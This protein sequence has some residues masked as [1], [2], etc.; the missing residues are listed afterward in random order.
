MN[1]LEWQER[2]RNAGYL[3]DEHFSLMIGL[4]VAMQRPLLLEGPA[5]SGKTFLAEALAA[6]TRRQLVRLS[7]YEGIDAAQ[8][9]YDWNYH[10]QLTALARQADVDPFGPGF[11]LERPLMHALTIAHGAVLLIDEVDRADEGFEALLLEFL[12]GYQI[13]VP[14]RD[15][16]RAVVPP[17]TVLTSNRQRSLS[18]ALRRRCLYAYV[19]WPAPARE[20]EIV[21]L[22]VPEMPP[23]LVDALVTGVG[24]LRQFGLL[25][26][27]GL[28]ET[29]DWAR[30]Q[31]VMG[32]PGWQ[33]EWVQATLG[34]VIKDMMDF[35]TVAERL[36][37]L[38]TG[39]S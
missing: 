28:A 36:D 20:R 29:V 13:T 10:K 18:D 2:L 34:C 8:A 15:T 39:R 17:I 5:G 33:R 21:R 9:L 22:Y 35:A 14:E 11:L 19:D 7:C 38:M 37:D 27:P 32:F 26:P 24:C 6:A 4:A 16:V 30:A 3:A 1:P 25:K 31:R 12:S 23:D